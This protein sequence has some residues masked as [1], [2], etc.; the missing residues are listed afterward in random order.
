MLRLI[1]I[2]LFLVGCEDESYKELPTISFEYQMD[3]L[4][5]DNGYY[6]MMADHTKNNG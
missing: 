3:L 5:D 4:Q 1:L 2:A 6:H